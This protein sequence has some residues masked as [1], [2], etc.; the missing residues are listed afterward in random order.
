MRGEFTDFDTLLYDSLLPSRYG[1][2]PSPSFS[3]RLSHDPSAAGN[4]LIA[5]QWPANRRAVR[6][7]ATWMEAWN[8]YVTILVASR[9]PELLSYQRIICEA[10]SHFPAHCWLRYD[11]GLHAP[12]RTD[13]FAG[14]GN[15]MTCGWGALRHTMRSNLPRSNQRPPTGQVGSQRV[16]PAHIAEMYFISRTT[17]PTV[18]FVGLDPLPRHSHRHPRGPPQAA[19]T[20]STTPPPPTNLL[21]VPPTPTNRPARTLTTLGAH[22]SSAAFFTLAPDA[23]HLPR[24]AG[25]RAHPKRPPPY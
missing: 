6:D 2:S 10:S 5:Q 16:D 8:I 22:A 11:A 21:F 12:L 20:R 1:T 14:T 19:A 7:L 25:V 23:G 9:T 3:F 24:G 13:P 17:A 4:V 18:P 15:I